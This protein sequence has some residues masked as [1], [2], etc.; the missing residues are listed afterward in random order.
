MV[1]KLPGKSPPR[2]PQVPGD[3]EKRKIMFLNDWPPA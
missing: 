3:F 1:T 2:D